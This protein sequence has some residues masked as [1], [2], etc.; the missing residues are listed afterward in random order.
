MDVKVHLELLNQAG[1]HHHMATTKNCKEEDNIQVLLHISYHELEKER[2]G[3]S[4]VMD[5]CIKF[6]I[7]VTPCTLNNS[8]TH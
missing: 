5:D 1:D 6:R 4:Y 8:L 2:D 7:H 3:I